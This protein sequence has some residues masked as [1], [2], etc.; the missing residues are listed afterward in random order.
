MVNNSERSRPKNY[1]KKEANEKA[2]WSSSTSVLK[3]HSS[4]FCHHE[5]NDDH[6]SMT[7]DRRQLWLRREEEAQLINEVTTF[8]QIFSV[9]CKSLA[10]KLSSWWQWSWPLWEWQV[11]KEQARLSRESARERKAREPFSWQMC[12]AETCIIGGTS[13]L[14]IDRDSHLLILQ[15]GVTLW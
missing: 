15:T 1:Q 8:G 11:L 3:S 12:C 2:I 13:S 14:N 5:D 6:W 7:I 10:M 9:P 4:W